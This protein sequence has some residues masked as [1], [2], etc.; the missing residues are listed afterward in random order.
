[1]DLSCS[2]NDFETNF[3]TEN[4]TG[5]KP[6]HYWLA[7]MYPQSNISVSLTFMLSHLVSHLLIT[8]LDFLFLP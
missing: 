7:Y 8:S 3:K 1:M 2:G 6:K 4:I 5:K